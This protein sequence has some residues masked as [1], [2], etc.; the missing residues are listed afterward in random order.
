MFAILNQRKKKKIVKYLS[1][2]EDEDLTC[3]EKITYLPHNLLDICLSK[4][5]SLNRPVFINKL[6]RLNVYR[7]DDSKKFT[8]RVGYR[9]LFINNRNEWISYHRVSRADLI[10]KDFRSYPNPIIYWCTLEPI[11]SVDVSR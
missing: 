4:I 8:L 9:D 10:H 7:D 6:K 2:T 3:K 1:E 11:T 5:I